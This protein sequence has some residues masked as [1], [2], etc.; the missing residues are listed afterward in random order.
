MMTEDKIASSTLLQSS[1]LQHLLSCRSSVLRSRNFE[2]SACS[3]TGREEQGAT[4]WMFSVRVC[5]RSCTDGVFVRGGIWRNAHTH[6]AHDITAYRAAGRNVTERGEALW[7]RG[8]R[9][10]GRK[11]RKRLG[12]GKSPALPLAGTGRTEAGLRRTGKN[13]KF[14]KINVPG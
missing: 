12:Q 7:R 9:R 11:R 4:G 14:I 8:K 5:M 2:G 6:P 10:E 13:K 3:S 1:S